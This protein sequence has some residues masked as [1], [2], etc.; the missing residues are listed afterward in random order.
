[1]TE[2]AQLQLADQTVE[3]PVIVGSEG[4]RAIDITRLRSE[5]GYVTYDNGYANT[6]AVGSAITF[7]SSIP[8]AWTALSF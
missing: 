4:E 7:N 1:M 5:T 8:I 6:G 2:R 3:L